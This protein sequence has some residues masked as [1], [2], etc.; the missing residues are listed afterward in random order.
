[1]PTGTLSGKGKKLWEQVYNDSVASGDKKDVA[2]QK[3]WSA[4]KSAGWKK[5][6][7][8]WVKKSDDAIVEFSMYITKSSVD[9]GVMRWSAINSDTDADLYQERMSFAL[10][11]D[12]IRRIKSGEEIPM[13]FRSL[14]ASDYWKGGM[15][16]VSVS[17][18]PDLNGDAVPGKPTE[19]FIDGDKSKARLKAKGVLFDNPLGRA[20]W[21]SLSEDKIKNPEDRI[22]ISI[23]FLDLEHKHGENGI[24]FQRKSAYSLCPQCASGV[25]NK[26]YTK[27]YL[28]HL[29]LTRVPVNQRTE[30]VLEEKADMTQKKTRK[31]DAASIV[32]EQLADEIELKNKSIGMKSD[33]LVEMSDATEEETQELIESAEANAEAQ[34]NE[35]VDNPEVLMS[36]TEEEVVE[37]ADTG[38]QGYLVSDRGDGQPALP[39]KKNGKPDHRLM[40]AAWAALHEGYRGNKY[41]GKGKSEAIA[42]LKKMYASENMATPS[43]SDIEEIEKSDTVVEKFEDSTMGAVVNEAPDYTENLPLNGAT[44]MKDAQDFMNAQNDAMYLMDM[45]GVFCTVV[46]NIFDRADITDKRAALN[47]AVDEFKNVLTLK[48][49]VMFSATEKEVK[50]ETPSHELQPAIDLLLQ[51]VDNSVSLKSDVERADVLNPVLQ[52]LGKSIMDYLEKKSIVEEVIEQPV[53]RENNDTL[54]KEIKDALQPLSQLSNTV[55][56]L[57]DDVNALKLQ[58]QAANVEVKPRIPAPRTLSANLVAKSNAVTTEKPSSLRS[59]IRKSVGIQE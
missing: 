39:T 52:S 32:G 15:P 49:M 57:V 18:Y 41:E 25:G 1:M 46:C 35:T 34:T 26:I 28:V 20:V 42:K 36:V 30:M 33:A 22:R 2:A 24:P 11:Q 44:S 6:D 51:S 27:G 37:K 50:P 12:F 54:L 13:Q 17:H 38:G 58:S 45:W 23:G 19:I 40:G 8:K 53:S 10:Y 9:Q 5:V 55:N 43:K 3:A 47:T 29:A 31:Q 48:A 7:N 21:K 16:Y 56:A 14:V 4:V 59:I